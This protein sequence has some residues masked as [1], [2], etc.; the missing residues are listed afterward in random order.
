MAIDK[1]YTLFES[2][3]EQAVE[4]AVA[5]DVA[6]RARREDRHISMLLNLPYVPSFL[7]GER[8]FAHAV[9]DSVWIAHGAMIRRRSS[10]NAWRALK[11]DFIAAFIS[12][13]V[14]P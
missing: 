7:F 9:G 5:A 6:A 14:R 11:H 8:F 10:E 12:S 4:D 2:P 3:L 1:I 13:S